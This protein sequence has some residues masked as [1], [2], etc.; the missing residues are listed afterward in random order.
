MAC[1]GVSLVENGCDV[2]IRYLITDFQF[3]KV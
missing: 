2:S 1:V 3:Q